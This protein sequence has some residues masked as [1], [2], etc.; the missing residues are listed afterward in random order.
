MAYGNYSQLGIPGGSPR[1]IFSLAKAQRN[2]E[3]YLTTDAPD[4][5]K[6]SVHEL[7]PNYFLSPCIAGIGGKIFV[8]SWVTIYN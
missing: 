8:G 2:A 1:V 5:Y 3:I 7:V 4:W 6:L